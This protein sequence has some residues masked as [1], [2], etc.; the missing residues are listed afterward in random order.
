[1]GHPY[2]TPQDRAA[3]PEC[4]E[5]PLTI[6]QADAAL[7]ERLVEIRAAVVD[8]RALAFE[9]HGPWAPLPVLLH[10]IDDM[11]IQVLE[12]ADFVRNTASRCSRTAGEALQLL[13]DPWETAGG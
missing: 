12:D 5:R 3:G 6:A 8:A 9:A 10:R 7:A 11:V 2:T 1:M 4:T 13:S